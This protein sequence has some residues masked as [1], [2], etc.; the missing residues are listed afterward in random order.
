MT[1][2]SICTMLTWRWKAAD[3]TARGSRMARISRRNAVGLL[4][5]TMF[6]PALMRHAWAEDKLLKIG[7]TFPVTGTL[8]L[9]AGQVRDAALYAINE[10]N[11]KGGIAGYK[12]GEL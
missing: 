6:A 12:F 3:I 5:S 1:R 8:A 11:E 10:G 9:Q 2:A 7:M 4:G